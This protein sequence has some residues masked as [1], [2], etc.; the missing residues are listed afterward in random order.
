[1]SAVF[2]VDLGASFL[3]MGMVDDDERVTRHTRLPTPATPADCAKVIWAAW[4]AAGRP[5]LVAIA[6]APLCDRTGRV[7]RWPNRP[8]YEGQPIVPG[9]WA[10]RA[11]LL[12]DGH[13]AALAA[14]RRS[15]SADEI[16]VSLQIGTG[17]GAGAVVGGQLLLGRSASAMAIGHLK[18]PSA[19]GLACSCGATG[20]LQ[21][22]ASGRAFRRQLGE[23]HN[24][25]FDIFAMP[26]AAAGPILDRAADAVAEALAVV[27]KLIDP[28]RLVI[29]GSLGLSPFFEL[30]T[31]RYVADIGEVVPVRHP[32]GPHAPLVGAARA[33]R[34][35]TT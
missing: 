4:R 1:M 24:P 33:A 26:R 27:V 9:E 10:G 5:K 19:A 28:H 16:T 21:A 34:E 11:F 18:V 8:D 12:D 13:A 2:A 32:A 6:A 20:C 14:H 31:A 35:V 15:A 3:R 25:R 30:C 22:A 7:L 23:E 29:G 17:I